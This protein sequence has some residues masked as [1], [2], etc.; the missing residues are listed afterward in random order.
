MGSTKHKVQS[1]KLLAVGFSLLFSL[2]LLIFGASAEVHAQS[3]IGLRVKPA[4][5]EKIVEP[6]KSYTLKVEI[7]NTTGQTLP[8]RASLSPLLPNEELLKPELDTRF[9]AHTW[10]TLENNGFLLAGGESK[11]VKL[12]I[13][14]PEDAAPGGHYATLYF[15]PVQFTND[16]LVTSVPRVASLVLLSVPGEV[17]ESA[18]FAANKLAPTINFD[19]EI[20]IDLT[21]ENIGT[22][23][24]IGQINLRIL[25][26][27]KFVHRESLSPKLYLPN[28]RRTA[29]TTWEPNFSPW[30]F[31]RLTVEA[32]VTYGS[33]YIK[34]QSI[35]QTIWLLPHPLVL[36]GMFTA[37][38]VATLFIVKRARLVRAWRV[39]SGQEPG[40]KRKEA[41]KMLFEP[42]LLEK[43]SEPEIMSI[44]QEEQEPSKKTKSKSS[45][46]NT[47]SKKT[48]RKSTKKSSSTKKKSSTKSKK[49]NTSTKK[50]PRKKK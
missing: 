35:P 45:K 21:L 50:S 5:S 33:R 17:S 3:S 13:N 47:T 34:T 23:H 9:N 4:I 22:T 44:L 40:R 12:E 10:I 7:T 39:L 49:K 25:D 29:Q 48:K 24:L 28:T 2:W 42:S 41:L 1:T 14:P 11:T 26:D 31:K 36:I 8:L 46:S 19:R 32:D 30:W 38:A 27:E 15:E 16:E 20:P 43:L 6:G 18:Q 37:A